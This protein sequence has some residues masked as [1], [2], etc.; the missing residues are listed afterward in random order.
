MGVEGSVVLDAGGFMVVAP[1]QPHHTRANGGHLV[2]IP[3]GG[4]ALVSDLTDRDLGRL[5][6]LA[7]AVD[8]AA[9]ATLRTDGIPIV[10]A[11]YQVNGNW[12]YKVDPPTPFV[13]LHLYFRSLGETHA[14]GD[15]R[16]SPFPDAL[17]LPDPGDGYYDTFE[18]LTA[19]DVTGIRDRLRAD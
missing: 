14:A 9:T 16:F 10:R 15:P 6:C 13:H 11:N 17:V 4:R 8:R 7:A 3:P 19:L 1:S 18:P 12:A 2:V 5:M